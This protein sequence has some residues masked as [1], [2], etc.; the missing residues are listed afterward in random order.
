MDNLQ[1]AYLSVYGDVDEAAVRVAPKVKGAVDPQAQMAGRSDAGKRISGDEET[2]PNYYTKGRAR[3]AKPDAPTQPGQKPVGTP[4]LADWEKKDIQYRKA[5]LRAGKVH[6]VGGP[7]GLPEE[8]DQLDEIT[9]SMGRRAKKYREEQEQAAHMERVRAH[10]EKMAKEKESQTQAESFDLFDYLLEYLVAEGYADT[11][12]AA[13]KIMANMSEE[14]R[15]SIVEEVLDEKKG[16][17]PRGL[18]YGPVG[19]KFRE[20]TIPQRKA[21]LKRGSEHT[22][23][24]MNSSD[25]YSGSHAASS[26]IDSALRSRRLGG[27]G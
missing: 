11:N 27:R 3:G 23:A 14:W 26:A 4:K 1:E 7:K 13:I 12:A 6:K 10:Q 8:V 25:E 16:E 18:P 17:R 19:K 9:A 5:N 21:M 22:R 20:L 2:G 15:E 24:A